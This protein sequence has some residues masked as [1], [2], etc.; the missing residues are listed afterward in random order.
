MERKT[1]LFPT[2]KQDLKTWVHLSS[3]STVAVGLTHLGAKALKWLTKRGG[4]SFL[5]NFYR[6]SNIKMPKYLFQSNKTNDV[7]ILFIFQP[8]NH[9]QDP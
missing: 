2:G 9:L 7:F 3:A 6:K 8:D 5:V 1:T 4:Q